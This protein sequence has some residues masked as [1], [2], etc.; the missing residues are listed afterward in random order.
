M[1]GAAFFVTGTDTGVGKTMVSVLLLRALRARGRRALAMKPV[2]AGCECTHGRWRNEDVEALR[3]AGSFPVERAVMNPYAFEPPVSPHLAAARAGVVVDFG[4]VRA[5]L[6]QL[7]A[8]ADVVVVEGAG[9]WLAPLGETTT[10]ADLAVALGLPVVLVVGLRLGCLSHALLSAAAV[11]SSGLPLAGWVAN[12]IDPGMAL[13]DENIQTLR[14]RIAAPLLGV[15]PYRPR[16]GP[17]APALEL[18]PLL[19]CLEGSA[20]A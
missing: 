13:Q 2:A 17:D 11:S 4:R 16:A 20:G 5:S 9:G 7:C 19:A 1:S 10:M 18:E 12:V 3:E 6:A 15:V 8:Q 14:A